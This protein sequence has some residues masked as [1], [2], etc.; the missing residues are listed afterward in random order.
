M[1]S[2]KSKNNPDKTPYE[3]LGVDEGADFED[4][5]KARDL[6]VKEAGED[7][8]LKAKIESSFDQLLMG[9]LKARQ[10]GN[11]SFEAQNASK[12]EKQINKLINNDFPLLS[13]IKNLNNN[14]NNS[15]EYSL[16]KI[17]P[18]S[19]DN[20]SIKLSVGL[21]FLIILLISPDSYNR[22]LLS[23]STLI[24]TYI[25]IKSG[26]KFISSLGWSVTFLSIGLIFG[27][28]FETNSFIQE[29]SNNSLSIQ[30]IQSLPAMIILWIGV[31]FL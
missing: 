14:G 29:I 5:Q 23:V 3:I 7:L 20:L 15:N 6:K 10:S 30:K 17:T 18:P 9:S 19:F 31:I 4:I 22:L 2:N 27:G 11:V 1:D 12:K 25:Q 13:K 8:L 21:L 24:L 26:K 16:P 28:L